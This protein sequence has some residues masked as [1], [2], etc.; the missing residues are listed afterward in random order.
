MLSPFL[1]TAVYLLLAVLFYAVLAVYVR[2][3]YPEPGPAAV[4]LMVLLAGLMAVAAVS[5]LALGGGR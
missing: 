4:V 2:A 5:V 1:L 3:R